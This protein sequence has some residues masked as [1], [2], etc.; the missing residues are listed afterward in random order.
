MIIKILALNLILTG[1]IFTYD[2]RILS[3][4]WFGFGDQN[5][6]TSRTKN[7]RIYSCNNRSNNFIC[8]KIKLFWKCKKSFFVNSQKRTFYI[9][10][11]LKKLLIK[12]YNLYIIKII[13]NMEGTNEK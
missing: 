2:A 10:K 1:V 6:A 3:N 13:K 4:R 8:F 5:E 12:N 9:S 7:S 11:N